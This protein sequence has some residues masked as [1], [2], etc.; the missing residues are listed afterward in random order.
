[1]IKNVIIMYVPIIISVAA[2][3]VSVLAP[4][5]QYKLDRKKSRQDAIA[6]YLRGILGNKV[7]FELP[8]KVNIILSNKELE[9]TDDAVE[10]LREIRKDILFYKHIDNVFYDEYKKA[11]QDIEDCLVVGKQLRHDT[12]FCEYVNDINVK[13]QRLY[14]LTAKRF[15]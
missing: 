6:G 12:D 15:F 10:I 1:M 13:L 11:V 7:F 14:E 9:N 8:V 4:F 5:I 2:L 3:I